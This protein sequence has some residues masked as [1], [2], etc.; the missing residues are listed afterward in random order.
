M[1][2]HTLVVV[3][4]L[5]T[6]L[7]A[8]SLDEAAIDTLIKQTMAKHGYPSL[9]IGVVKDQELI[10][11]R[12]YGLADRQANRA[13][14]VDSI[15]RIGSITK[16]FTTTVMCMLRDEG[17][18]QLDDPI[19]KYL[20]E[21]LQLPTDPRGARAITFRHLATHSSGLPGMPANL[22]PDEGHGW[23]GYTEQQL[24]E[25]LP[26]T[27]L[28]YPIGERCSYSN[29]GV[30]LLGH[31]LARMECQS[32]DELLASRLLKPLGMSH[33]GCRLSAGQRARMTTGYVGEKLDEPARDDDFGCLAGCGDL[34]SNVPDLAKFL[35]LQMREGQAGVKPVSGGTLRELHTPQRL[36]EGWDLAV[37]LAG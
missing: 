31:I 1:S 23:T 18:F 5:A 13:A 20:P 10:F 30:G 25:G 36:M 22:L 3:M 7:S 9:S 17:R 34:A 24:Y 21:G 15:Y 6:S 33:T 16:V 29:L 12:A 8:A 32:Y 19:A 14:T 11:A 26:K 2:R 35:S 37:G 28:Q 4:T 27:Q